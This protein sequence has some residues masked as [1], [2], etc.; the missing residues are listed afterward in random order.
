MQ[1]FMHHNKHKLRKQKEAV[2]N[3]TNCTDFALAVE[4][5]FISHTKSK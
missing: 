5:L 2:D 4:P 3:L 1:R